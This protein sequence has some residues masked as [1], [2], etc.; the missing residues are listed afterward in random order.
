MDEEQT[1]GIG[2][3]VIRPGGVAAQSPLQRMLAT[4]QMVRL[5][6]QIASAGAWIAVTS[7]NT[8]YSGSGVAYRLEASGR[9]SLRGNVTGPNG[10][11]FALPSGYRPAA[12]SLVVVASNVAGSVGQVQVQA[13]TG[14]VVLESGTG[15]Y[16]LDGVTLWTN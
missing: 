3:T 4:G 6:R 7:F 11:A 15:T 12:D 9:L 8:G 13:S 5:A 2:D 14:A 10:S 1:V 16:W